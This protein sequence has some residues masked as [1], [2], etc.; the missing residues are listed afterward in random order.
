MGGSVEQTE[1]HRTFL[2]HRVKIQTVVPAVIIVDIAAA[3]A[4][5]PNP[6]DLIQC[7]G[8]SAVQFL[9]KP[10]IHRLAPAMLSCYRYL[11]RFINQI[12]LGGHNV[13]DI[14][15]GIGIKGRGIHMRI[16]VILS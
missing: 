2:E 12:L 16:L 8:L 5:V 15:Q 14:P 13:C 4:V 3:L 7:P 11:K 10:V 6:T 9:Q 1:L